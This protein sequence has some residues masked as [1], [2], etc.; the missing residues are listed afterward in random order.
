MAAPRRIGTA[1]SKTRAL[2]VEVTQRLML[3]E[4]Y[5]AVTSRRVASEAGVKPALV[6]YYF[7]SMDDLFLAVF[8]QG[9]EQN[10]ERQTR[11]L[12]SSQPLRALWEFSNEPAGT[13]LTM[14]FMA[15]ANHRKA[16]RAEIALYAERFRQ[17][18]VEALSKLLE[19]GIDPEV[20]PP[21]AVAVFMTSLSRVLVMEEALGM[22]TGHAEARAVVDGLLDQL[23][24]AP[25]DVRPRR[26]A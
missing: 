20:C 1:S 24:G 22:S 9:A 11:A 7:R 16:I 2:L 17:M 12:E 13:A 5:A 21:V 15:L 3:Q 4:G 23:E 19:G 6:H 8:R 10:L 14:E 26:H 18:Q 25:A